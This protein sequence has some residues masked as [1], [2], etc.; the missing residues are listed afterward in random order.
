[1]GWDS[2]DI[3]FTRHSVGSATEFTRINGPGGSAPDRRDARRTSAGLHLRRPARQ[4]AA[5]G[6]GRHGGER[7]GQVTIDV[8]ANDSD[9]DGDS[10]RVASFDAV[11]ARGGTIVRSGASLVYPPAAGFFGTDTFDYVVSDGDATDTGTVAVAVTP[12]PARPVNLIPARRPTL[13][14]RRRHLRRQPAQRQHPRAARPVLE[15]RGGRGRPGGLHRDG[16]GGRRHH[17]PPAQRRK[18]FRIHA[19][20]RPGR[21]LAPDR[22]AAADLGGGLIFATPSGHVRGR[23]P[24]PRR[25]GGGNVTTYVVA[26][27]S[28]PA[29]DR[30]SVAGCDATSATGGTI[31]YPALARIPAPARF[32]GIEAGDFALPDGEA[33]DLGTLTVRCNPAAGGT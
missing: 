9:P 7:G 1:M 23:R 16:L 2:A 27:D 18:P 32:T 31:V 30:M 5:H 8:L 21:L 25:D 4:P 19:C 13:E 3:T 29:R 12:P 17:L 15:L 24:A 33:P 11:S 28:D 10:L 26:Y 20:Q 6:G 14:R 22:R